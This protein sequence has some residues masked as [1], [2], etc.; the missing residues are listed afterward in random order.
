[1]AN[2][3][4]HT[5]P[6]LRV[7]KNIALIGNSNSLL[8]KDYSKEIDSFEDVIR[9]NF[10]DIKSK[11]TGTKTTIR[12]FN[13]P[14]NI[15]S[16]DEHNPDIK[17]SAHMSEYINKLLKD[18]PKIIC[19]DSTKEEINKYKKNLNY[20]KPNEFCAFGYINSYLS[21]LGINT[22]FDLI[23]NCWPRTG[24]H[25]IITCL[26]S[27]CKPHLYGFDLE[28]N[29]IIKHYSNNRRYFV[30]EMKCH[31]V[32]REIEILKELKQKGFIIVR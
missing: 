15:P 16:A 6:E 17:N 22:K 8:N 18:N 1:M 13:C 32:S 27:G 9:F 31:Q 23:N 26:R 24:F 14:I 10:G 19:W 2:I 11:Y 5:T 21:Q 20:Y 30:K 12:W 7:S 25:A 29:K 28:D 3:F 4:Y